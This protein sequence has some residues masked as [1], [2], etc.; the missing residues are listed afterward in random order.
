[1]K[2]ALFL[3]ELLSFRYVAL[4]LVLARIAKYLLF[5][6]GAYGMQWNGPPP[7]FF[8]QVGFVFDHCLMPY[9]LLPL[10]G[11][12]IDRLVGPIFF[13][14]EISELRKIVHS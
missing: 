13:R 5:G 11:Y 12:A 4:G 6:I 10:A 14:D 2:T 7:G 8:D 1:M 3:S 9:G